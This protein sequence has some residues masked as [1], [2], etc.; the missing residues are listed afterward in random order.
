MHFPGAW[1]WNHDGDSGALV[2]EAT[3]QNLHDCP[4]RLKGH[5][6]VVV[7]MTVEHP[8]TMSYGPIPGVVILALTLGTATV[9]FLLQV[10]KATKLV[11]LG[12][13]MTGSTHGA[14]VSG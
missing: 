6:S 13:P 3:R 14:S 2:N 12:A 10:R 9:F 1:S 4:G 7:M 5:R 11:M 8:L